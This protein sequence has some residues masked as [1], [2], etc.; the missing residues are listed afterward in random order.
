MVV[1]IQ[2]DLGD[3]DLKMGGG[4]IKYSLSRLKIKGWYLNG[5]IT[6]RQKMDL[7]G[8]MGEMAY[9]FLQKKYLNYL[10][11]VGRYTSFD[12]ALSKFVGFAPDIRTATYSLG[13]GVSPD[14][15]FRIK[16]EYE[17]I[18]ETKGPKREN[19]QIRREGEL[20]AVRGADKGAERALRAMLRNIL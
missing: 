13:L 2:M 16:G 15:H 12:V 14:E 11:L 10:E 6:A 5:F 19:N 20:L 8:Y 1:T 7:S 17:W 9:Q 4:S 18:K 3:L